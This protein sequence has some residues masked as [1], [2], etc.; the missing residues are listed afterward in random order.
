[1][2]MVVDRPY[3]EK[4]TLGIRIPYRRPLTLQIR[5]EY[6]P[7]ATGWHPIRF[8]YPPPPLFLV[9]PGPK[10]FFKQP[11]QHIPAIVGS[12]AASISILRQNIIE[13]PSLRII[14]RLSSGHSYRPT[15]P[16]RQRSLA[17]PHRTASQVGQAT[18]PAANDVGQPII[19]LYM[20]TRHRLGEPAGI[21]PRQSQRFGIPRPPPDIEKPRSGSNTVIH[22][23]FAK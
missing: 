7:F 10:H 1:M 20:R 17:R 11:F 14:V 21:D 2:T 8:I 19:C 15:G 23:V 6:Q 13:D 3:P 22:L 9:I 16:D 4:D 12:A 18:V 5:Q